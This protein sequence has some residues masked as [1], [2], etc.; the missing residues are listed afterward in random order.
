[1]QIDFNV[2]Q[3]E[4]ANSVIR[5]SVQSRWKDKDSSELPEK[6]RLSRLTT[7]AGRQIDFSDA[8]TE[9]A[10]LLEVETHERLGVASCPKRKRVMMQ[11]R[12]SRER[13]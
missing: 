5:P 9:N 7:K 11:A 8:Q 13:A 6:Q 4:N 10:Y 3:P 12:S 1:M 2:G